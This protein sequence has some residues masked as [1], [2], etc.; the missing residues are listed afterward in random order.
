VSAAVADPKHILYF[1]SHV[2]W[3]LNRDRIPSFK[4]IKKN[5]LGFTCLFGNVDQRLLCQLLNRWKRTTCYMG[6]D[7]HR[8]YE[9]WLA[10]LGK[11]WIAETSIK[12]SEFHTCWMRWLLVGLKMS[13]PIRTTHTRTHF[14]LWRI[15]RFQTVKW[16][17]FCNI[18]VDLPFL[19]DTNNYQ[20]SMN[21]ETCEYFHWIFN[22]CGVF[23]Y[24]NPE[25]SKP[26]SPKNVNPK[27]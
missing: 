12:Q 3:F 16:S 24:V 25:E 23:N 7:L 5:E 14:D 11:G 1:L 20:T 9:K 18:C 4:T 26:S 27:P 19:H 2:Y 6:F 13:Y 10:R 17:M 15:S 22:T 8:K 21:S